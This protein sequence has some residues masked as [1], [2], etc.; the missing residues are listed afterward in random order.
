MKA[1]AGLEE[2]EAEEEMDDIMVDTSLNLETVKK[3]AK[4]RQEAKVEEIHES[5]IEE[6]EANE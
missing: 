5:N 6:M 1:K 4:K 2:R 3:T